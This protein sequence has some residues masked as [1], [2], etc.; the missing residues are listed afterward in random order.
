[1][2]TKYYLPLLI[3][4]SVQV[5]AETVYIDDTQKFVWTRTGP[6]EEFRV[7]ESVVLSKL[8]ILQRNEN[9]N[10]VQVRDE[11][12]KEF[13]VKSHYLTATPS[14][15]YKLVNAENEIKALK[16]S[17]NSKISRLEKR[18]RELSPLET[19]NKELQSKLASQETELEQQRQKSAMYKDGFNGDAF[20]YGA[21]VVLGGML[22]GWLLSKIGGRRRNS[23]WG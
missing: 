9:S 20:M 8:E 7:R 5:L 13:W 4:F 12:G 14:A 10:F 23:G 22:L 16:E 15:Q 6:T 21:M 19:L 2:K 1:M 18:L 17:H 3:L 11:T